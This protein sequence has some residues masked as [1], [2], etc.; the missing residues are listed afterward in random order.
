MTGVIIWASALLPLGAAISVRFNKE[1]GAWLM[2][3]AAYC[4]GLSWLFTL[5]LD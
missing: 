5:V 3:L 4:V 1:A 2:F